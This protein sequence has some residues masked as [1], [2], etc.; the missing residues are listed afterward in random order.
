M[1][2]TKIRNTLGWSQ[3]EKFEEGLKKTIDWYLENKE[4]WM[5]LDQKILDSTP[6]K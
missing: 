6:W 3:K 1:E 2:S 5:N 4:W